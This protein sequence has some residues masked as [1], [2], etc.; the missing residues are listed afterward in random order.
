M[1]KSYILFDSNSGEIKGRVSGNNTNL[2]KHLDFLKADRYIESDA[3]G[4]NTY[5][6][7]T[8]DPVEVK[9]KIPNTAYLD[10]TTIKS[11]PSPSTVTLY[12]GSVQSAEVTDERVDLDSDV[13]GTYLVV[14]DPADAKYYTAEFEVDL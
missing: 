3:E 4:Q 9:P 14:V 1:R 11:V 13:P 10:G 12:D 2:Q 8:K 5:V 7:V 6:D